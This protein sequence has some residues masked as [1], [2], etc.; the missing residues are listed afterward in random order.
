MRPFLSH[1]PKLISLLALTIMF[2]TAYAADEASAEVTAH[3]LQAELAL[4]KQEREK[5]EREGK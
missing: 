2:T 5:Q 3:I 4:E 1:S